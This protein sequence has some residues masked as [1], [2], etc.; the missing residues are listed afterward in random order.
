[1]SRDDRCPVI[2]FTQDDEGIVGLA[3]LRRCAGNCPQNGRQI[4][5]AIARGIE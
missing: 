1:M 2:I 4:H 5:S 3:D